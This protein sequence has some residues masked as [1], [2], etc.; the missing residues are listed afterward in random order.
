M[1]PT[2]FSGDLLLVDPSKL[3]VK[4]KR[5]NLINLDYGLMVKR[6]ECLLD[7]SVVILDDNTLLQRKQN[8][9]K[10]YILSHMVWMVN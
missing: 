4:G 9:E 8:L 1:E 2:I 5:M 7:G 6:L 3:Q 10:L